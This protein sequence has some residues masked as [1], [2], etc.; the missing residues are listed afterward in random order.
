LLSLSLSAGADIK[1]L[2]QLTFVKAYMDKFLQNLNDGVVAVR[3]PIIAA[4]NGYAV[5]QANPVY[6]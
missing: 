5:R 3:K 2:N 4:V 1:E 6:R